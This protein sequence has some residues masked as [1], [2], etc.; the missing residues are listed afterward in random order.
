[1]PG[2]KFVLGTLKAQLKI[3]EGCKL[4][5]YTDTTGH[6][7]IGVGHNLDVRPISPRA[8]DTILEDDALQ[9]IAD[10][11]KDLTLG[12]LFSAVSA[13]RQMVLVNMAFN[14]GIPS[15]KEFKQFLEQ[16]AQARYDRAAEAMLNSLWARQVG[17]R[18]QRLAELMRQD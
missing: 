4:M 6:H 10:I 16:L 8:A 7:T 12:P 18:A 13:N 9:T 11:Q 2:Y 5:M 15:L 1:M 17:R 3:D 14:L